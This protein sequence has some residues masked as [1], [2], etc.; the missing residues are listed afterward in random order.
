[1]GK[2]K[3]NLRQ[4]SNT[5]RPLKMVKKG[6]PDSKK[7]RRVEGIKEKMIKKKPKSARKTKRRSGWT[8]DSRVDCEWCNKSFCR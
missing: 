4:Y 2:I 3:H 6:T 7:S 5:L 1:M 8:S